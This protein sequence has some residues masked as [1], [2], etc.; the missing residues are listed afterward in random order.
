MSESHPPDDDFERR[1]RALKGEVI[2]G[3]PPTSTRPAGAG[4]GPTGRR[5]NAGA[6][7]H[8]P[9]V[10]AVHW[11]IGE[12]AAGRMG[13]WIG[14]LLVAFGAYLVL[15]Q[16]VPGVRTVGSL[17]LAL[18]G[19]IMLAW[20][21]TGRAGAWALNL[22][23]ILAGYGVLRFAAEVIGRGTGGWGTLGA[24]LALFAVSAVRM[25]RGSGA[26][27]QAWIGGF[28]VIWGGWG[29]LGSVVPGFPSLGDL[30]VPGLVLLLGIGLLRR[31]LAPRR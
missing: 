14:L 4:E 21:A 28:F 22:G 15:E 23:A 31:G 13:L 19:G 17:A 9:G 5:R 8:G 1:F 12:A 26:G 16:F 7:T 3:P 2:D 27:W 25:R 24:G 29:A 20:V 18:V 10:R 6:D 30:L 11:S